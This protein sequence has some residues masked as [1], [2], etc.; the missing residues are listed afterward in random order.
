M[1]TSARCMI[2]VLAHHVSHHARTHAVPEGYL[3]S[4]TVLMLTNSNM[5]DLSMVDNVLSIDTV[6]NKCCYD[7]NRHV[8]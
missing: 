2:A 3:L 1:M 8:S 5:A 7:A 4:I 6:L